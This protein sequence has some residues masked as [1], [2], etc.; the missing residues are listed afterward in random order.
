MR[1]ILLSPFDSPWRVNQN[2]LELTNFLGKQLPVEIPDVA[3]KIAVR[4][5]EAEGIFGFIKFLYSLQIFCGV[6]LQILIY[7]R[8]FEDLN[9]L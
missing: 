9:D 4:G 5:D 3:I 7:V 2:D 6:L 8:K 1:V